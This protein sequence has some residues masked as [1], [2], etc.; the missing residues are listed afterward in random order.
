[1]YGFESNNLRLLIPRSLR[2]QVIE[3]LHS[4]NQGSSSM[5]ARARQTIYWPG[6]DRDIN[7]HCEKCLQCRK[8]SPSKQKE[9]LI[10]SDIPEYPFQ[11]V[12]SDIFEL[13]DNTYLVY[14]DRLTAFAEL[15][16]FPGS[17]TSTAIINVFREFYHRW[18]APEEISL[19]GARNYN[20]KEI[21]TWFEKWGT[22]VRLSSAYYPQS[23]GRA[24]VGVKS[25]KRLLEG[26]VG[27]R[28]S[29]NTYKVAKALMQYRNTPLRDVGKSP[30]QLALGRPIR[31][32]LP[33]PRERYCIDPDWTHHLKAREETMANR[34]TISKHGYDQKAKSLKE[35]NVGDNVLCQNVRS[36]KWDKSGV[37]VEVKQHRQYLIRI[38]GSGRVSLRNRRHLQRISSGSGSDGRSFHTRNENDSSE[39]TSTNSDEFKKD[40]FVTSPEMHVTN[41]NASENADTNSLPDA[42]ATN[43]T[44]SETNVIS[45]ELR[46][47]TRNR[48]QPQRYMEEY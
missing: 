33:L 44:T 36:K 2:G 11:Q 25:L 17:P 5:L 40:N 35:M 30:A 8:N 20:S 29:I 26:N 21:T 14:I 6:M 10:P 13:N 37:I 9:P 48:R 18:G 22:T 38:D 15:A 41:S 34:N 12:V 31:D 46:R 23:N 43:E 7:Q 27:R 28:G 32:T 19:D 47:S 4:A 45:P 42:P 24:E 3:N 16:Y 1:M 39:S